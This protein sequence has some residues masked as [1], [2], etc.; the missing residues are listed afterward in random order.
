MVFDGINCIYQECESSLKHKSELLTKHESQKETMGNVIVQL[1]KKYV[2]VSNFSG[3]VSMNFNFVYFIS[4]LFL[5]LPNIRYANEI[6]SLTALQETS[7]ALS[8]QIISA[9]ERAARCEADLRV[10]R[11]WRCEMQEKETKSKESINSLQLNIKQLNDELKA[12]DRMRTELERLRK[13]W[14]EAQVTLEELGMQ[15]SFSKLQ[16]SE[17][18]EKLK[19]ADYNNSRLL[20]GD[21][22]GSVWTPDEAASRCKACEREFSLTRRKVCLFSCSLFPSMHS[23]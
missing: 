14:Q 20:S 15:L 12:H 18:E 16:V 3:F 5:L 7:Q 8:L 11:E 9:E 19:H 21:M 10:E 4:I 22:N 1:E 13:Q 6:V 2:K 17:M 23:Q